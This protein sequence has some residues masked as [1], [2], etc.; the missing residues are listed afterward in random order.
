MELL[1]IQP[2]DAFDKASETDESNTG[3]DKVHETD[4]LW[5]H[6]SSGMRCETCMYYN[7]NYRCKRHAPT[8]QGYPAVYP[9]DWCGDHKMD[10]ERMGGI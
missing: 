8:M 9:D 2:G 7:K 4:D 3:P 5:S 10:K 6:R 1:P